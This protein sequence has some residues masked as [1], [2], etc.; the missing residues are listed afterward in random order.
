M[1]IYNIT[2]KVEAGIADEW[3]DWM[4]RTHIPEVLKTGCFTRYQMLK[5]LDQEK[6]AE[7]TYAVQYYAASLKKYQEYLSDHASSFRKD[8]VEKWGDQI[9]SFRT[10]MEVL[11]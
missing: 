5:L 4:L 8:I 6:N 3:L 2:T 10:V 11:S 1:L 9:V 7:P